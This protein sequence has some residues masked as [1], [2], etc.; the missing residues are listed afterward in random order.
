MNVTQ[1]NDVV[2]ITVPV[3]NSRPYPDTNVQVQFTIPA[4]VVISDYILQSNGGSFN[5]SSKLWSIGTLAA[6]ASTT[7]V[8][9]I[10][11]TDIT[12]AP[13]T[14]TGVLS[15]TLADSNAGNNSTSW[16]IQ[17]DTCPPAAGANPDTSGCLC[18]DVSLND[19]K[20]SAGI[21]EWRLNVLSITNSTSPYTWDELTGQYAFIPDDN[22]LPI[23]FTYDL[24]CVQGLDEFLIQQSVPVTITKQIKDKI[25]YNHRIPAMEVGDMTVGEI[26]IL[27]AD[28]PGV[29]NINDYCWRVLRNGDGDVVSGFPIDCNSDYDNKTTVET[30]AA[31]YSGGTPYTGVTFPVAPQT[32]DVHIVLYNNGITFF[33]FNVNWVPQF[34]LKSKVVTAVAVSGTSTKTLTITFDDASFVATSYTDLDTPTVTHSVTSVTITSDRQLTG[35]DTNHQH[36]ITNTVGLEVLLPVSPVANMYFNIKNSA[37]SA[38]DLL[39]NS[40]T[41]LPN[42]TYEVIYDGIQWIAW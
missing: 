31:N 37:V 11:A 34:K 35:S 38:Q 32:S 23:T 4:G 41:L 39:V 5:T 26:A 17:A 29:L 13:F 36:I 2:Q 40:V 27:L 30:I 15:G 9:T 25:P 8:L 20:C 3:L 1:N 18:G 28:N 14:I 21:T 42:D 16:V 22:S 6:N 33:T 10:K 24:Y 12:L 7:L 19:T